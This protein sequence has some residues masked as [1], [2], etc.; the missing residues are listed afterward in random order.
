M[1][2]RR[3]SGA[4]TTTNTTPTTP[5]LDPAALRR[6]IEGRDAAGLLELYAPE[7]TIE[8]VD[9]AHK[10]SAPLRLEGRDAIA[11]H[12]SDVY[13]RDM[14][15]RVELVAAGADALGYTVR[16]VYADGTVV[17]CVAVAE[18]RDGRIVREVGAQAWDA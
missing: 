11:A 16:C 14:E 18:V 4:M 3:H 2:H 15:H 8:I 12:L 17:R 1:T 5:T 6:G 13:G 9:E 7:A 10:P